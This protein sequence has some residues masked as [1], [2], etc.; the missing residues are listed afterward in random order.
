[1]NPVEAVYNQIL[2]EDANVWSDTWNIY[3]YLNAL[4]QFAKHYAYPFYLMPF[5]LKYV[6]LLFLSEI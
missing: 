3:A 6:L 1:M 4:L 5:E 2:N